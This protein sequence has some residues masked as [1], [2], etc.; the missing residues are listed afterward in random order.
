MPPVSAPLRA[1]APDEDD[2]QTDPRVG[3]FE[4]AHGHDEAA[5]PEDGLWGRDRLLA[6]R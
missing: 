5:G 4:L 6:D 3:W 1:G 2:A